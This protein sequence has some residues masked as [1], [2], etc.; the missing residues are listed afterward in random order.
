MLCLQG[1]VA[2]AAGPNDACAAPTLRV[3]IDVGHSPEVFGA[4]SASGKTE[5]AFNDRFARELVQKSRRAQGS[6][7]RLDLFIINPQGANLSLLERPQIARRKGA[8]IFISIHHDS[9]NPKHL[10]RFELN[11]RVRYHTPTIR[12]FSLFVS[13]SNPHFKES[14]KLA[15]LVGRSFRVAGMQPTL[16]H[17]EDLPNERREILEREI[18]L[19][20]APFAVLRSAPMPSLL[21][22][23]GVIANRAEEAELERPEHRGRIQLAIIEALGALCAGRQGE[24][25]RRTGPAP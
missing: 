21:I 17:A 23:V 11:D 10:R 13:R 20:E 3:A 8:A 19:Y 1:D 16:H 6:A 25:R 7:S 9:V 22:E 15:R 5:Y 18:G 12:G 14:A 4:V 2:R 24:E